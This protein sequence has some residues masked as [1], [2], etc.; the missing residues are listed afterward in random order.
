V[1]HLFHVFLGYRPGR[2][3]VDTPTVMAE[4]AGVLVH[5]LTA[6]GQSVDGFREELDFRRKLS[7]H[8]H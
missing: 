7:A 3:N 4:P 6:L 8:K 5:P 1:T 2:E